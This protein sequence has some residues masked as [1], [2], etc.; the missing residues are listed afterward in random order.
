MFQST[1]HRLIGPLVFTSLVVAGAA[2]AQVTTTPDLAIRDK[3]PHITVFSDATIVVAP[4]QIIEGGTLVVRDGRVAAVGTDVAIPSDAVVHRLEGRTIFP[5]FVEPYAEYGLGAVG[6]VNA[7]EDRDTVVYEGRRM[8]PDAWNEAIHSER[9]WVDAFQPDAGEAEALLQ[10]GVAVV[11]SSKLDGIFRGRGFVALTADGLANEVVLASDGL[12]SA[13]FHKGSSQQPYPSSLMGSIALVRQTLLDVSWYREASRLGAEIETNSSLAALADYRGPILFDTRDELSLLR[14]GRI[15][16]E[17]KVPFVYVGSNQE[18]LH[19]EPIKALDPTLVLPLGFPDQPDVGTLGATLD[20]SL[21]E[22]R[23]WERAPSNP[24]TLEDAGIT[25][26]F[27]GEKLGDG[28][29]LTNLRTAVERGLSES[30]ALAALTTVPARL[31]GVADQVGTLEVGRLAN[32]IVAE[33]N[34]LAADEKILQVWVRGEAALVNAPFQT[35]DPTG[36]FDLT[37]G[38]SN[39]Q[40]NLNRASGS[41]EGSLSQG[42]TKQILTGV[43]VDESEL[44]FRA[45]WGTAEEGGVALFDLVQVGETT[46]GTVVLPDGS[47][48]AVTLIP[49]AVEPAEESEDLPAEE[50]V[51]GD[52]GDET[53][54][55]FV[56][57]M[58]HPPL[59]FGFETLPTQESVLVRGATI[60]TSDEAGVL[61]G[62]DLLVE[63][64]KISAVGVGLE[65]PDGVRTIDGSGKHVTA[66]IIDEH[67]HIA[68]SRGVNEGTHNVTSE[69]RIADVVN[70][71]HVG[72]YR[73]LGGGVTTIQQLHGSANPIGGQASIIKLRWGLPPEQLKFAGVPGSIKFALGE[74]VKQSNWGPDYRVRYPQTRMGVESIMRDAFVAAQ[75][76][77]AEH[78]AYAALAPRLRSRTAPPRR[79]LQLEALVEILESTR[80]I[81][82]HSYVQSEILMLMRLAEELGFRVQTFTHILEGYKVADEMARHGAGGSTFSDWWAYKFE[83]FDAIPQNTCLM[84]DAGVVTSVNSDSGSLMRYLNQEA[85]KSVHYCGMEET[86][87]LNLVT[88]NPA[89]QLKIDDRVGSLRPGKDADFV[90]W[91]AHPLSV[92]AKAEQTWIDGTLYFSRER[93]AELVARD[94][95]EKAAL[96]QKILADEAPTEEAEA[97]EDSEDDL[98][99]DPA[100]EATQEWNCHS[101]EAH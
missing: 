69:V 67:S 71:D 77:A 58:T 28:D 75:E 101:T 11:H 5:A 60:W 74:N 10:R 63:N 84:H 78:A 44:R 70:S 27:T 86:D 53:A 80:F 13:S 54:T 68:I 65:A 17:M 36:T 100:P 81:H 56:S 85:A 61:E 23:H 20:V 59:A 98:I 19:L 55:E 43:T 46:R 42:D 34:L 45:P 89:R 29:F 52:T 25:F 40:L 64:G 22:L 4:G 76:Y 9:R 93:D 51:D 41:L 49:T 2:T 39:Y 96:I 47:P 33:G 62:A 73:A 82:C 57:R 8:G 1:Y 31:L 21:P 14:A 12:H 87:A 6:P 15:A 94:R 92:Y 97:T 37:I 50:Y 32:L 99:D 91:D 48:H 83:V 38:G 88:I 79:D 66:G 95:A 72:I 35:F 18:Y 30:T 90:I 3:T 7:T 16:N 24:A 26:A